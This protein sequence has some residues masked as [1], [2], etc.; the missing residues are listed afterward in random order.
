[1][2][3]RTSQGKKRVDERTDSN[4]PPERIWVMDLAIDGFSATQRTRIVVAASFV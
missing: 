1:L 4:L 3:Q 2:T